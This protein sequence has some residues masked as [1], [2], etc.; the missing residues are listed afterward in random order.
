DQPEFL[1]P[2]IVADE[3][4]NSVIVSGELQ[5][6]QRVSDIVKRL[7]AE[8]ESQGNTRVYYLKYAKA[9]DIVKVLQGVSNSM[10]AAANSAQS[11]QA[12]QGGSSSRGSNR[13]VSI[14]AHTESNSVIVTAQP[15]M[16]RNLEEVIRQV[17]IR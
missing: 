10:V 11:Q 2:K 1:I 6:R 17:D 13:E 15:D 5:A 8:Q 7:D 14:E 16:L 9:E 12:A 3:R 4:T